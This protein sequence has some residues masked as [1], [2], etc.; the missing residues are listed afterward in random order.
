MKGRALLLVLLILL[1]ILAVA[2]SV[3][4]AGEETRASG[5][6]PVRLYLQLSATD[7]SLSTEQSRDTFRATSSLEFPSVELEENLLVRTFETGVGENKGFEAYFS[8]TT[9]E[10]T[11]VT[12]SILEDTDVIAERV[13]DIPRATTRTDWRIPLV[14]DANQFTF[15]R[16]S[17]ITLRIQAQRS[18]IIRTDSASYLEL[19]CEN[20]LDIT[21]ETRDT[22][23]RRET[24][25]YP[26]D[27]VEFRHIFIEGDV[28][29]P[30]G[31]TDVAGVN[32]SVRR[33]DGT[34]VIRDQAATVGADMN[35][36]YDWDYEVNL[37][38]GSYT[39]NVTGR[40]LQ[41]NEFST[42]G[43][44]IMAEYGVRMFAEGEEDGVVTDTTTPGAPA[45][46]TL[47][48][49]NIGGKRADMSMD[50]GDLIPLWATAFSRK[51]F[52][53]DA[54]DDEDVTFDVKPSS[55]LGGGNE[56]EFIVTV[57][58]NNDPGIPKSADSLIVRTYVTNDVEL[59]VL[60]E[61]PDP[62]T[63]AVGG[64]KDYTFTVRNL[65]EFTTNVDL[66]RTGVPTGWT[67]EFHGTR[68][69]DNTIEDLRP[70]E[71]VD[72]I[73]RVEAPTSSDVTKADIK[74]KVQS[75]EYPDQSEERTFTFNL[76][77]G[78]A[79]T[80]TSPTVV[81]KDPGDTFTIFFE[82]RNDDPND[83]HEATFSVIQEDSSWSTS[84]FSFT[85]ST[86]VNIGAD[87]KRD[88]GLEV[89][90]PTSAKADEFNFEVRGIVDGN[91]EVS[92]SFDFRVTINLRR[93]LVV[94][95]DPDVS[96]IDINTEDQSLVYLMVENRGN[97][98]E[99][100]NITVNLDSSDV[101]VRIN[102]AI[103]SIILNLAVQPGA[104]EQVKIGFLAKDDAA[105]NQ[106]VQVTV[107][108]E[109]ASGGAPIEQDLELVVILS[110][111]EMVMKYL[112]WAIIPLLLLGVMAAMLL[113]KRGR[114]PE[115]IPEDTKEKDATHGTVVRH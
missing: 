104:T 74:V 50:E 91:T 26:N 38:S 8:V 76:V 15:S 48:I 65:G 78:L 96:K 107:S 29:N 4:V 44:F 88:M 7:S 87:S 115:E 102:D 95:L 39:I 14:D 112:E 55:T 21:T 47:T 79:L 37:D 77:I 56:S 24:N 72:V 89:T 114:K 85:P 105:P 51:T 9:T 22:E 67:G 30:F 64:T 42:I 113:I 108:T 23:D 43:S 101:V 20:H 99:H 81:T 70:M 52:S 97:Q 2:P 35:Y 68:I 54:G 92:T 84:S 66:T 71:I 90:V 100:V 75:R 1:S 94:E 28:E 40:D 6:V 63:V 49:L 86:K 57:T 69:T 109:M 10:A 80:P 93:E 60:P 13:R 83:P 3:P 62:V 34:Y 11:Q 61:D 59:Q 106:V 31:R 36:T 18:V 45:K 46:Y 27:L 103:T 41:G 33:P 111:S 98:V 19:Y 82:A 73:L 16:N 110:N 5:L 25:F 32:I 53:L 58:V 12:V 17:V